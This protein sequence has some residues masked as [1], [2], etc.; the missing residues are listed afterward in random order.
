MF[1]CLFRA[2]PTYSLHSAIRYCIGLSPGP[3]YREPQVITRPS[4]ISRRYIP[5][6]EV[7]KYRIDDMIMY[8]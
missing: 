2:T 7:N 5:E 8:V 6:L 1:F 4:T 3:N